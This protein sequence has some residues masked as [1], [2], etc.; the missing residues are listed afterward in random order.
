M[1]TSNRRSFFGFGKDKDKD[2]TSGKAV[3]D[4]IARTTSRLSI[5]GGAVSQN[6]G[7]AA[8]STGRQSGQI[9]R[10]QYEEQQRQYAARQQQQQG[11]PAGR[12]DASTASPPLKG[13]LP[14]SGL[15]QG[16]TPAARS[17]ELEFAIDL[18]GLQNQK[19]YAT[20]PPTMKSMVSAEANGKHPR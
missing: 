8:S 20:S 15:V 19:I 14:A 2:K 18:I 9:S 5:Q 3:D 4:K 17:K 1:S 12:S 11:R 6:V 7:A 10:Q 16:P 13:P